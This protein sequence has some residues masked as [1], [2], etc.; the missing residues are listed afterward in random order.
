[1]VTSLATRKEGAVALAVARGIQMAPMTDGVLE[2]CRIKAEVANL[3]MSAHV[4]FSKGDYHN[5]GKEAL[6]AAEKAKTNGLALH[7]R[8]AAETYLKAA[9]MR[10]ESTS[11]IMM[12]TSYGLTSEEAEDVAK[13][14]REARTEPLPPIKTSQKECVLKALSALALA[15]VLMERKEYEDAAGPALGA[16]ENAYSAGRED[17]L[18]RAA[19]LYLR[20]EV[21]N[22]NTLIGEQR[23]L[24]YGLS[25][26]DARKIIAAAE[27]ERERLPKPPVS[28][29]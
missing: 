21:M 10:N 3:I 13:A 2:S 24:G 8:I 15:Q 18:R 16:A 22:Y 17:I 5:A 28:D 11:G 23:A 12:A 6:T 19:T 26:D 9:V 20:I 25:R 27:A 4:H 1:M 7:M 14:T 29:F